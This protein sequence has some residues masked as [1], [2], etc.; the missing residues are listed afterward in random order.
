MGRK[1]KDGEKINRERE[2]EMKKRR[3]KNERDE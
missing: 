1:K 3:I 2:D